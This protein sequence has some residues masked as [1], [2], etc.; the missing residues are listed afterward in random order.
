VIKECA[1]CHRVKEGTLLG[2]LV[3]ELPIK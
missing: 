1:V 2:T 3:Y